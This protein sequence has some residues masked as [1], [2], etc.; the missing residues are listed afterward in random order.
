MSARNHRSSI[1]AAADNVTG[2]IEAHLGSPGHRHDHATTQPDP[3]TDRINAVAG[4][5]CENSHVVLCCPNCGKRLPLSGTLCMLGTTGVYCRYCRRTIEITMRIA[6]EMT[7]DH[8]G[9]EM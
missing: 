8:T 2:E 6:D 3:R 7:P 4:K 1:R 5:S 9:E